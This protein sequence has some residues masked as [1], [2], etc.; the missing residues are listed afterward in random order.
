MDF[1]ARV[2]LD[3]IFIQSDSQS[4]TF[5]QGEISIFDLRQSRHRLFYIRFAEIIEVLLNF[6]ILGGSCKMQ[7]RSGRNR[8]TDV[9]RGN[10]HIVGFSPP[11]QLLGIFDTAK[12]GDIDL[13]DISSLV[14]E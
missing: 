1:L 5:G 2:G 4:G 11:G 6:E 10:Q 3:D 9:M 14:F 13:Q 12:M 7:S 8:S